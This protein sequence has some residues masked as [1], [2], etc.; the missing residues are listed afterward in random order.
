[1][2]VYA[3]AKKC[4]SVLFD[5]A[6]RAPILGIGKIEIRIYLSRTVRKYI[7]MGDFTVKCWQFYQK[8]KKLKEKC[9]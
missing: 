3:M 7:V 5:W 2:K 6:G 9:E 1:M 4:V 8:S